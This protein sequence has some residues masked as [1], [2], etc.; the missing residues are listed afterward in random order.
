MRNAT[1]RVVF[2][3]LLTAS[4]VWALGCSSRTET[5]PAQPGTNQQGLPDQTAVARVRSTK[6]AVGVKKARPQARDF[7]ARVLEKR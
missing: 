2:T 6:D 7:K 1:A 3:S 5:I 4:S